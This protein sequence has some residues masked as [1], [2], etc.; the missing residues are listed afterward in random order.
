MSK[1]KKLEAIVQN[2]P[3][4]CGVACVAFCL[5][6]SYDE[7]LSLFKHPSAAWTTG[8]YCKEIA[9]V[10]SAAGLHYKW[11]KVKGRQ[12]GRQLPDQ[13]IVFCAPT[14]F[15][16]AGH[17]LVKFANASYMNPWSN[18]PIIVPAKASFQDKLPSRIMY[19]IAPITVPS[20]HRGPGY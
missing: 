19:V 20:Q 13:T 18:C 17:F 11:W 5:G 10:L 2:H 9:A 6:L 1:K 4:G 16:P 12:Q 7:A 3:M 14:K 8:F 15:Y